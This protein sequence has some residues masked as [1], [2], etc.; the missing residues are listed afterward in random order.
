M[1]TLQ[2]INSVQEIMLAVRLTNCTVLRKD[3]Q[4]RLEHGRNDLL[5]KIDIIKYLSTWVAENGDRMGRH[6]S[7]KGY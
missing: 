2:R 4:N 3:Q 6:N 7:L 5:W 1:N